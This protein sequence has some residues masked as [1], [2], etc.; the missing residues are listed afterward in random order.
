MTAAE[1]PIP[2]PSEPAADHPDWGVVRSRTVHWYDP[3]VAVE[4]GVGLTGLEL[5]RAV[6]DGSLPPPPISALVQFAIVDVEPGY[7]RFRCTPDESVYNPLG[8]V[9]GGL[10]CTLADTSP[11]APSTP[12]CGPGRPTPPS[13]ST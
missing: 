3:M 12:P 9:H 10:V 13:T 4:K 7:V 6:R 2:S 8:V 11:A 5:L 1:S